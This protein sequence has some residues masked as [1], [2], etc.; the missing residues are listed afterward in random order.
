[1]CAEEFIPANFEDRLH[2]VEHP[3]GH[4]VL[5]KLLKCDR[6]L[7]ERQMMHLTLTQILC[8]T[9]TP[10][11]MCEWTACNKGCFVLVKWVFLHFVSNLYQTLVFSACSKVV[12]T[13]RLVSY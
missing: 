5:K 13:K 12:P 7:V 10:Q 3:C 2:I 11:R 9:I 6:I 4:F 8:D 1:M